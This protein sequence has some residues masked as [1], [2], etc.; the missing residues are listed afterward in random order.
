MDKRSILLVAFNTFLCLTSLSAQETRQRGGKASY[1]SSGLHGRR[2]SNGERYNKDSL[3]CAH[4]TLPFGTRLRVTNPRNGQSVVVRVTDRGPFVRGRILDLSYAAARKLGILSQ[5]VAYIKTEILPR[6]TE[7]PYVQEPK[8]IEMP[9]VEYGMAGVCYEFIP[10]WEKPKE[11]DRPKH[12]RRKVDTH[13]DAALTR[14]TGKSA[15]ASTAVKSSPTTGRRETLKGAQPQRTQQKPRQ[16]AK[17]QEEKEKKT[18]S[19]ADF[20]KRIKDGVTSL[21]E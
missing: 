14:N 12:I 1:Y 13:G 7:V 17:P 10:E 16:A 9:E 20:F 3:T 2:M 8:G 5:G 19:W 21:F 18:N 4:K 6:V 11:E 15:A